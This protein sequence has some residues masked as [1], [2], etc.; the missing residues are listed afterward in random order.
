MARLIFDHLAVVA[1]D[2][3]AGVDHVRALTGLSVPP[4]GQHPRMA[5][6]NCVMNMG[7]SEFFEIIAPDPDAPAPDEPRWFRL[8]LPVGAPRI[9]NWI[10][11]CD[12]LDAVLAG[13]PP[14]AGRAITMTRGAMTWR[15]A[16]PDDGGLPF[17]GGFPTLIEWPPGPLPQDAMPDLGARMLALEVSHP[18]A[19]MIAARLTGLLDDARIRF[20]P[21]PPAIRARITTPHGVAVL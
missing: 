17:D 8:D 11:R 13:L 18:N 16:V 1:D 5:T 21:G 6:R 2:L 4:G 15:I 10:C 7:A 3:G 14:S 19:A 20:M 12:D 9:G